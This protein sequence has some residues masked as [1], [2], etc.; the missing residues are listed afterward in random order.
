MNM[1]T[2]LLP[3]LAVSALVAA[4][5]GCNAAPAP[6]IVQ[7]PPLGG[8]TIEFQ[9]QG[10]TPAGCADVD[11]LGGQTAS[12]PSSPSNWVDNLRFDVYF[13]NEI[14]FRSDTLPFDH[15][16][17]ADGGTVADSAL[18]VTAAQPFPK[19]PTPEDGQLFCT[20]QDFPILS[21][22]PPS[23]PLGVGAAE[24]LYAI[25]VSSA[26]FLNGAT[27]QGSQVQI[28]ADITFG[29]CTATYVGIGVTPSALEGVAPSCRE[30]DDTPCSPFSNPDAGIAIGSGYN[31]NYPITC[32]ADIGKTFVFGPPFSCLAFAP[33]GTCTQSVDQ[34]CLQLEDD[35]TCK[36]E[37][38]DPDTRQMGV[39]FLP[40]GATFPALR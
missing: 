14:V 18:V 38:L 27:Y 29:T 5:A 35:G 9:R 10:P 24:G 28:T 22:F 23:P 33:D 39:C 8:F 15:T 40:K 17:D 34:Y 6:C 21:G 31:A 16:T 25:Q 30:G 1:L 4:L 3:V 26:K 19:D 20:A 36:P 11:V 12:G 7:R 32:R 37:N 2:R 13:G